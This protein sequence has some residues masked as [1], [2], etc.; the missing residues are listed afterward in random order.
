MILPIHLY[1]EGRDV[2]VAVQSAGGEWVEV[3]RERADDNYSHIVEPMGIRA[4]LDA[5][6]PVRR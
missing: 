5:A 4:R 1:R 3:I 6:G 2:V